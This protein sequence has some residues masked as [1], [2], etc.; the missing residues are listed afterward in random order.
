[1][2]KSELELKLSIS[3]GILQFYQFGKLGV[4]NPPK[5]GRFAELFKAA[6]PEIFEEY[7]ELIM[8]IDQSL[9][10]SYVLGTKAPPVNEKS[11][12]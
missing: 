6:N 1:M 3:K 12:E 10:N 9:Y 2:N 11:Q 7:Q 5:L 8:L 4:P